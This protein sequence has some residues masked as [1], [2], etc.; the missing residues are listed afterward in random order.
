MNVSNTAVYNMC[1]DGWTIE[2]IKH[3]FKGL[4]EI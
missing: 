1:G 2:V 3:I 4:K